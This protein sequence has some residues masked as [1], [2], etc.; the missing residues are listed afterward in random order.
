M[1]VR[2]APARL[3][4]VPWVVD[5]RTYVELES[6]NVEAARL[7]SA[8]A[9]PGTVVLAERQTAGRGR[10]GR[11]WWSEAGSSLTVSWIAAPDL[12]F[13]RWPIASLAAGVSAVDGIRNSAGIEATLKWPNDVVHA[14]LKLA[15]ILAEARPPLAVVIGLG[16]NVA[17]TPPAELRGIATTVEAAG[18][19]AVD[20]LAL[21]AAIL[22]R[23]GREMQRPGDVVARY[24]DRCDTLGRVVRVERAGAAPILGVA[25]DVDERGALVVESD[26]DVVAVTAGDVVHV[27]AT[28]ASESE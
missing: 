11:P 24:R 28:R 5:V 3:A 26:D 12:P 2:D 21:L 1:D 17:G 10:L 18:G 22:E 20:P 16:M 27:R 8:G 19:R 23:F 15:G 6:T 25:R 13:E 4:D 14:G 7:L 9:P